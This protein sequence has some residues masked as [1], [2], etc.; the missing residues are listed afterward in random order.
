MIIK[1]RNKISHSLISS[2][3]RISGIY[4]IHILIFF[5][6]QSNP[7]RSRT[8]YIHIFIKMS[9]NITIIIKNMLSGS[10]S[11]YQFFIFLLMSKQSQALTESNKKNH[12]LHCIFQRSVQHTV[13]QLCRS[14]QPNQY[15]LQQISEFVPHPPD[16]AE[17]PKSMRYAHGCPVHPDQHHRR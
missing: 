12:I 5:I 10:F 15:P 2:K 17:R 1:L 4:L 7:I 14:C 3:I 9:D 16:T 6:K 13:W 11:Q 8:M